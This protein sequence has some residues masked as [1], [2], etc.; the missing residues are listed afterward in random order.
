MKVNI[1]KFNKKG[2]RKTFID[3][4]KFDTWSMD[5]TLA[6]IILPMLL[7]LKDT[8]NGVPNDLVQVGG[9]EYD[10][11]YS[12]DF[13]TETHTEAFNLAVKRWD[14][15]LD[16]MIWSFEQI[17][18]DTY[19]DDYHHGKANYSFQ[20]TER[21]YPNPVTGKL[22]GLYQMVDD[23]PDK[24]WYDHIGHDLHEKRIQEGLELFG[25]YYRALWD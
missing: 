2:Y 24:H 21:K 4:E 22:E 16:K 23:N 3:I 13:Y 5:H 25:K 14:D 9:E 19:S 17:A 8:K 1:K 6:L 10:Q 18:F 12:F 15:I 7:Q 20:P 11:Q